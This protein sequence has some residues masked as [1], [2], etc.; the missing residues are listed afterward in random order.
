MLTNPKSVS[1]FSYDINIEVGNLCD[2]CLFPIKGEGN[3]SYVLLYCEQQQID[4]LMLPKY[5]KVWI[6]AG[7]NSGVIRSY[8]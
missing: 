3:V 8:F 1:Q 5:L 4:G 7:N 2:C 6:N